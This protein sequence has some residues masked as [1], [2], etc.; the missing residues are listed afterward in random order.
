[1]FEQIPLWVRRLRWRLRLWRDLCAGDRIGALICR[2]A[3][4]A[5][6]DEGLPGW[7]TDAASERRSRS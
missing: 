7:S 2:G 4:R 5:Q 3:L 6:P 1:M